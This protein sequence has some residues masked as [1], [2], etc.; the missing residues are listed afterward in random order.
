[1]RQPNVLCDRCGQPIERWRELVVWCDSTKAQD[2]MRQ[3]RRMEQEQER[4]AEESLKTGGADE[5]LA[6]SGATFAELERGKWAGFVRPLASVPV[7]KT[8]SWRTFHFDCIT[9][10]EWEWGYPIEGTRIN[11]LGK[12]LAWT[13]H[14]QGKTWYEATDWENLVRKLFTLPNP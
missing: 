6:C 7:V 10:E 11:T 4:V 5:W 1:M 9:D 13:L 8:V 3:Y 2:A 12:A 14:L